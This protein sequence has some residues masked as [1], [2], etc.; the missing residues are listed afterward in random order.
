MPLVGLCTVLPIG[1]LALS[2][3]RGGIFAFGAELIVLVLLLVIAGTQKRQL[4]AGLLALGVAAALVSWLGFNQIL[5]RFSEVRNPEVTQAH[6]VAMDEGAW[7][8]FLDHPVMGIGLGTIISVFPR[9]ETAYDGKV[10]D[11]VHNDH[12]ELLAETGIPGGICWLAF[13]ALLYLVGVRYLKADPDPM[14]RAVHLGALVACTGL[15]VHG[16]MDFN[17]HIPSNAIL[18]FIMAAL[19]TSIPDASPSI[20]PPR[21]WQ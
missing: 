12:L 3:S 18:F 16:T 6:R 8:I 13:L 1:A 11:H 21:R 14:V 9:Y 5:K 4:L 20:A 17:L 10:V 2:A 15:I 7:R 19:A